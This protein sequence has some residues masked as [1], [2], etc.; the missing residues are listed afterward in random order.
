MLPNFFYEFRLAIR[1]CHNRVLN[2]NACV[3]PIVVEG[4]K[5]ATYVGLIRFMKCRSRRHMLHGQLIQ[6]FL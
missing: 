2:M 4:V 5:A 3:I 6:L 1:F